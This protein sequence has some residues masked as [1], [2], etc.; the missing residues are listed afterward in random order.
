VNCQLRTTWVF[1][2]VIEIRRSR[3]RTKRSWLHHWIP[4]CPNAGKVRFNI[5]LTGISGRGTLLHES[6][7]RPWRYGPFAHVSAVPAVRVRPCSAGGGV[8]RGVQ[9]GCTGGCTPP[10]TLKRTSSTRSVNQVNNQ[11][12][13][14]NQVNPSSTRPKPG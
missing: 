9:G 7:I 11:L 2:S 5:D 3:S 8:P 1:G 6:G 14:V 4:T 12:N 13:Q 10:G